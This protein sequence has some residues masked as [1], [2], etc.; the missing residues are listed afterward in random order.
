MVRK[1]RGSSEVRDFYDATGWHTNGERAVDTEMFGVQEDGPIRIALYQDCVNRIRRHLAPDKRVGTLLELGCGGTPALEIV[2]VADHYHGVDFSKQGL[3]L[4]GES[5]NSAGISFELSEADITALP[6]EDSSFDAV[7]SAHVFYHIDSRE[8]QKAALGEVMRVLKPGGS[9]VMLLGNP[10]PLLFPVRT[11]RRLAALALRRGG[12]RPLPYLPLRPAWYAKHAT[13][14]GT[15]E[16]ETAGIVSTWFNQN[17]SEYGLI[18]RQLW[19]TVAYMQT[20]FPRAAV[21]LGNY[22]LLAVHK[23]F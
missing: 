6:F 19:R 17:V 14:R 13:T 23:N 18:G 15:V 2:S 20:R 5:L 1:N 3:K 10:F 4:A 16:I 8:G 12:G 11:A 7:Y 9:A 22:F 21:Y